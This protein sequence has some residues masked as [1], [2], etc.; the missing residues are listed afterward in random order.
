MQCFPG[1]K[2]LWLLL[3]LPLEHPLESPVLPKKHLFAILL[4]DLHFCGYSFIPLSS[5]DVS[6]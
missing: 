2:I 3:N 5:I 1:K 4:S 6:N